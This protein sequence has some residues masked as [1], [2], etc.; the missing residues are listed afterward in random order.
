M[1]HLN[2]SPTSFERYCNCPR[3]WWYHYKSGWRP[4]AKGATLFIGIIL[5]ACFN[6]IV[7]ADVLGKSCDP[8]TM[9][10]K[11]WRE[12]LN[13]NAV[14]FTVT[15]SPEEMAKSAARIIELFP[16][17]W[18]RFGLTP[19]IDQKGEPVLERE[20]RTTITPGVTLTAI[21]DGLFMSVH[22]GSV[23]PIDFKVSAAKPDPISTSQSNQLTTQQIVVDANAA[24]LGIE[25]VDGVGLLYAIRRNVPKKKGKGIGPEIMK[26]SIVKARTQEQLSEF[27]ETVIWTVEDI[28]RGRFPKTP[29]SPHN[30]PCTECDY[31]MLCVCGSTEGLVRHESKQLAMV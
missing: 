8:Q 1:S 23:A 9:F 20:F 31:A 10:L 25:N 29:R 22:D 30:T 16:D 4:R 13:K 11:S 12:A 17:A 28:Q 5:H 7:K 19:I 21:I 6:A 15:Q 27:K 26:P 2:I 3:S 14:R 24:S 18:K